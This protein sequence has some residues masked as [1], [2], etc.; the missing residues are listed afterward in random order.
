MR[1]L[2]TGDYGSST[3]KQTGYKKYKNKKEEGDVWEEGGRSWTIKNGVKQNLRKLDKAREYS[4][5]PLT[6]P[7]CDS[8]MNK[9]QHKFMYIRYG[10]CLF[11]Q[12]KAEFEMMRNGTHNEWLIDNVK[13]NFESWKDKKKQA[14]TD[15]LKNSNS[16]HYITEAGL[17]EDW[18]EMSKSDKEFMLNKFNKFME[19]EE[20]K[21]KDLIKKQENK[22]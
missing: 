18:S 22:I 11:C 12:S 3:K 20:I 19:D 7:K 17:I 5:I 4:R 10:H 8:P 6:C 1:N 16:K 13:K 9:Q 14:F 15:Y 2:V 21:I